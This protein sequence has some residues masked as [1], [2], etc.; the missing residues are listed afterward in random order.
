MVKNHFT[1]QG[2][3]YFT[4]AYDD[5]TK[6]YPVF[7]SLI[8]RYFTSQFDDNIDQMQLVL[9]GVMDPTPDPSTGS[10]LVVA[11]RARLIHWFRGGH[12]Q[13]IIHGR[14]T[15]S[16]VPEN[17]NMRMEY[18]HLELRNSEQYLPRQRVEELCESAKASPSSN[19][20]PKMAKKAN[21][22]AA[23]QLKQETKLVPDSPVGSQGFTQATHL[24]FEV[25]SSIGCTCIL[26]I[27]Y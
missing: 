12:G 4:L 3:L 22:K 1:E 8:P 21:P 10:I 9:E 15:A 11:E 13:I 2:A 27:S 14:L 20:S 18:L 25:S 19:R 17:S 5:K 7:N 23:A 26:L 16:F 24:W 6:Q